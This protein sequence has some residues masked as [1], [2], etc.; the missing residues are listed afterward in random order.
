MHKT[1]KFSLLASA[2]LLWT[3]ASANTKKLYI[4][5]SVSRFA[6]LPLEL[7]S[8]LFLKAFIEAASQKSIVIDELIK[9]S[10]SLALVS[11]F[12]MV[13]RLTAIYLNR[14]T[15]AFVCN[16]INVR[17]A[18]KLWLN[19]F[20]T[21]AKVTLADISQKCIVTTHKI[22]KGFI[23][24]IGQIQIN[25]LS[26][27][28]LV[29]GVLQTV[30]VFSLLSLL[31]IMLFAYILLKA[32]SSL[33]KDLGKKLGVKY[34]KLVE[35]VQY[36][37][38]AKYQISSFS[39]LDR[40]LSI[41]QA[42]DF[43]LRKTEEKISFFNEIPKPV[44][45]F[46]GI[47][48]IFLLFFLNVL[49]SNNPQE[50][51]AGTAIFAIALQRIVPQVV[52]ISSF[53]SKIQGSTSFLEEYFNFMD[54]D[55]DK[56]QLNSLNGLNGSSFLTGS[57]SVASGLC[58]NPKLQIIPSQSR[59]GS[60]FT[61]PQEIFPLTINSSKL[62]FCE[63]G[64]KSSS[65]VL[66][67]GDRVLVQG[68]SG[69]GKT[70]LFRDLFVYLN[71]Y[72]QPSLDVPLMHFSP[73]LAT[74]LSD[75][76][77]NNVT[78]FSKRNIESLSLFRKSIELSN[79]YD[80]FSEKSLQSGFDL[81]DLLLDHETLSLGE[82]QRLSVAQALYIDSLIKIYDEPVANLDKEA[83]T[84]ILKSISSGVGG[85]VVVISHSI[86]KSQ[87]SYFN[88]IISIESV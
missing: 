38:N 18:A 64:A 41:L 7:L 74:V 78:I 34:S 13:I 35:F 48:S 10:I 85:L 9:V 4:Y 16:N 59:D 20:S 5:S 31:P 14:K 83:A 25:L 84:L 42:K 76:L 57:E 68:R 70:T 2:Q 37:F 21:D 88:R 27:L 30:P 15:T 51:F 80:H 45:E 72:C 1:K 44:L 28:G 66:N 60:A 29:I 32:C 63:S 40:A 24:P 52:S 61:S 3:Q 43:S 6:L 49:A 75:T 36:L 55:D 11:L 81:P 86:S 58:T 33:L 69:I 65:L 17:Y 47:L 46:A 73:S 26:C 8:L 62:A 50:A 19:S 53:A 39:A 12:L 22:D 71:I 67:Y 79:L 56:H 82:L 23:N 54:L 77:F 87:L